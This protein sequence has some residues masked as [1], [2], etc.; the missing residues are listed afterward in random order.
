MSDLK[1]CRICLSTDVKM[2]ELDKFQ[3]RSYYEQIMA[4]KVNA[5]SGLPKYFC[6]QCA[7]LLHKYH[8][9][10]EKCHIGQKVLKEILWKG[11]ITKRAVRS[12]DRITQNLHTPLDI[13]NVSKRVKTTIVKTTAKL[14][15]HDRQPEEV[16][17]GSLSDDGPF[18]DAIE[19]SK[20]HLEEVEIEKIEIKEQKEKVEKEETN[21]IEI[22]IS[23][24][25]EQILEIEKVFTDDEIQSDDE[26]VFVDDIK[27]MTDDDEEYEPEPEPERKSTR[28]RKTRSSGNSKKKKAKETI[29]KEK[30]FAVKT[31]KKT[32]MDPNN[33]L[34]INLTEEEADA[35]F[36]ARG[37]HKRYLNAQFKCTQCLKGFSKEDMLKRHDKLRH[38]ES[39]GPIEC[40][41][42]HMR[43]KWKCFLNK[44]MRQHYTKYK[45]LRCDLVCPLETTALF[46]EEYHNGVTRKCDHCG[47]EFKHLTTYY[48][49]LRT[50]RSEHVC[51]LCGAS[52]VSVTG[53]GIHK[54][55]KHVNA[56]SELPQ[57]EEQYCQRCDVKFET[58]KAYEEHL[59]HSA[60]HVDGIE[61]L[62][63]NAPMPSNPRKRRQ[64]FKRTTKIPTDCHICGKHFATQAACRKHHL[65][66]HPRTSF[67]APNERHICE[68]CGMSLAPGSVSSHLNTHTREKLY[69]CNTCGRQFSSKGGMTTHQLTHTSE[70]PVACTLCDKRFKQVS[71]MRLHYR[72]FHLKEP[73]PKRNR[74][75]KTDDLSK[76]EYGHE[77][78]DDNMTLDNF[79]ARKY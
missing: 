45:C 65:A 64:N 39:N 67:F 12:L 74:K 3:L 35:E 63:I 4:T 5:K 25:A 27:V 54:K 69:T 79:Y 41:F 68:I 28:K 22:E 77:D 13:I 75:K 14:K 51:T 72:T 37:Q 50:H 58:R 55:I 20:E 46:H 30:K 2:Y 73:Y 61:D 36:K 32:E 15:L 42:C 66:E 24:P 60:M 57:G 16:D 7:A 23:K 38:C 31:T 52:F 34:K 71:S 17:V 21:E 10:K 78:S 43:F 6:Y 26:K 8:K 70:K 40:R 56:E 49:H 59:I 53:L 29:P 19:D 47:E 9:F 1:I 33:W 76:D 62:E 11:P 18:E 48:T 44:H